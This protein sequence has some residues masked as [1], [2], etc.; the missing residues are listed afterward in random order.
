MLFNSVRAVEEDHGRVSVSLQNSEAQELSLLLQSNLPA[1]H[2][3]ESTGR[4]E[5]WN[6]E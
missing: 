2:E 5:L 6:E 4:E 1:C 3:I